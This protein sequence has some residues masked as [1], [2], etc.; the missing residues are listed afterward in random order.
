MTTIH[1]TLSMRI[2][3]QSTEERKRWPCAG[4]STLTLCCRTKLYKLGSSSPFTI[5]SLSPN[6]SHAIIDFWDFVNVESHF[7][8]SS[9]VLCSPPSAPTS[10]DSLFMDSSSSHTMTELQVHDMHRTA[11]D[12]SSYSAMTWRIQ[13]DLEHINSVNRIPDSY[14]VAVRSLLTPTWLLVRIFP[15]AFPSL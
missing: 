4:P 11:I 5:P 6:S 1:H 7:L 9:D 8:F 2:S 13:K 15:H 10:Q 12:V 14:R 3:L